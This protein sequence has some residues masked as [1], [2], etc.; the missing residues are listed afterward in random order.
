MNIK[1]SHQR[2]KC[3]GCL[4]CVEA[5]RDRWQMSMRD[6][7]STLIGG[8]D[9]NGIYSVHVTQDEYES[10]MKAA[11]C[12]PMKIIKVE[13]WAADPVTAQQQDLGIANAACL[14]A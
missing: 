13:T 8:V 5:N 9:S 10:T 11:R 3:I 2:S 14:V 6:G 4:A 7:K 1:I 12:C